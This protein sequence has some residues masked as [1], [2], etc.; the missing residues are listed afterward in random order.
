MLQLLGCIAHHNAAAPVLRVRAGLILAALVSAVL[1]TTAPVAAQSVDTPHIIQAGENLGT[2]AKRYNVDPAR[3][4]A[5]NHI[6]D[7]NRILIGRQLLIPP[8]EELARTVTPAPAALPGEGGYHTVARGESL[9]VIARQYGLATADLIRLNGLTDA[10][11]IF[12][13]QRLRLSARV[14]AEASAVAPAPVLEPADDIY[15]VQVGDTLGQIAK[16]YNTT[17]MQLMRDNG[18]PNAGFVYVGQQLRI[19]TPLTADGKLDLRG[20]PANG[21]RWIKVTLSTQTLTAYQGDVIVFQTSVATGKAGTPT[22]VGEFAIYS[23]L[24]TQNMFGEGWKLDDV[25]WV[26]YY[27]G[28]FAVHGAY[29]HANFGTPTSHGCV[30]VRVDEAKALYA[31]ASVGTR[32]VVEY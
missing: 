20:A 18:L 23:K 15:V 7:P 28:D 3:L 8:A 21:E 30:N 4:A 10:N 6:T 19:R 1:L 25:P 17:I 11:T 31:W 13:G 26:M 12:V 16:Q 14:D 32:V 5:Y 22:K 27:D 9:S 24:E 2:L 29:W